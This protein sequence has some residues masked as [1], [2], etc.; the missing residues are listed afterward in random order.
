MM[1]RVGVRPAV[2]AAATVSLVSLV[3]WSTGL[4]RMERL[5]QAAD[6]GGA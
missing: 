3:A 2:L 4:R 6:A 1:D 5:A